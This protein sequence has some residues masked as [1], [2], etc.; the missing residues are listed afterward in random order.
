MIPASFDY[1]RPATVDDAVAAL[2]DAGDGAKV[3]AGGQSL[4]PVL[5]LRLAEPGLLVDVGGLDQLREIRQDGDALVLG[6]MV[7]HAAVASAEVVRQSAGLLA[8]AA[9]TIGDRQVRHRGTIGGSLAHADPAGD[10]PAVMVALD[11]QFVL[12]GP[13]GRRSV[14]ATEFFVDYFTTALAPD[15]LLIEVRVPNLA[16]WGTHY[17]K[18][19]RTAQA[20]ATVAAAAAVRRANGTITDARVALT[21]MGPTP[22]RAGAV[23]QALIGAEASSDAL[24]AA[25]GHAA[26]GTSPGTD[27]TASAE[28]RT[29]LARVLTR[30]ALASAA[31]I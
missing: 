22:V 14:P 28:Y 15:E 16:G 17:A 5:R 21:N 4:L 12:A 2:A 1:I 18:V 6:A 13:G 24:A 27:T 30:R 8:Q 25:A 7:T 3:L 23:E 9:A 26:E 31:G 29:H 11:A 20:W 10:F 19:S